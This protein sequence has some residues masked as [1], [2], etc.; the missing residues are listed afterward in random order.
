MQKGAREVGKNECRERK[1]QGQHSGR[2]GS[3]GKEP[4]GDTD[5]GP[6]LRGLGPGDRIGPT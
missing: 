3:E 2:G 1:G 4:T 6:G 5:E